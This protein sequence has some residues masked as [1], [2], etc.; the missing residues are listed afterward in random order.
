MKELI[1]I[2]AVIFIVLIVSLVQ[3]VRDRMRLREQ[4]EHFEELVQNEDTNGND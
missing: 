4:F 3:Q 1:F 2:L